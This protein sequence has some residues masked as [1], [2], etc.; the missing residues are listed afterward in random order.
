MGVGAPA[1]GAGTGAGR[2][3][4]EADHAGDEGEDHRKPQREGRVKR[5]AGGFRRGHS[6]A[7][8]AR[9]AGTEKRPQGRGAKPGERNGARGGGARARERGGGQEKRRQAANAAVAAGPFRRARSGG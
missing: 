3:V 2:K 8:A 1:R 5:R 6:G 9:R 4:E 7:V